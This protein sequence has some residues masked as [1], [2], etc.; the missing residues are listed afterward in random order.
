MYNSNN[1]NNNSASGSFLLSFPV[2][3]LQRFY[4]SLKSYAMILLLLTVTVETKKQLT[5]T[6]H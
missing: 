6:G 1:V 2:M 3:F 4:Q 5:A